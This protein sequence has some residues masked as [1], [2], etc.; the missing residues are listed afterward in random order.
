MYDSVTPGSR[1]PSRGV[2]VRS[3]QVPGIDHEARRARCQREADPVVVLL[4]DRPAQ[5]LLVEATSAIQVL[6]SEI[7]DAD[8][9]I[10]ST[11]HRPVYLRPATVTPWRLR[12]PHIVQ[13]FWDVTGIP[14]HDRTK[15]SRDPL[16]Q[17]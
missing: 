6:D 3:Q 16:G 2:C 5:P 14:A 7:D 12:R 1:C 15:G 4:A 11:P 17:A 8:L 13:R 10:R 9:R